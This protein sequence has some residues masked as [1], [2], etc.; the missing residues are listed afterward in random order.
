MVLLSHK[1]DLRH[2]CYYPVNHTDRTDSNQSLSTQPLCAKLIPHRRRTDPSFVVSS[3]GFRERQGPKS[4][5]QSR[6]SMQGSLPIYLFVLLLK[7]IFTRC[8]YKL[9]NSHRLQLRLYWLMYWL[10][11][12]YVSLIDFTWTMHP[13]KRVAQ[14]KP[15]R[16]A[17]ICFALLL[18]D[19]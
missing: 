16:D 7:H 12:S 6:R 1:T 8:W 19:M 15:S 5:S 4:G 13:T 11:Y 9:P 3:S 14:D 17:D 2:K 18:A 10:T